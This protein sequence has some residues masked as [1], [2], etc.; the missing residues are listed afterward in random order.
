MS[1]PNFNF[2]KASPTTSTTNATTN[3]SFANRASRLGGDAEGT[4]TS[5]AKSFLQLS[6]SSESLPKIG[7][8]TVTPAEVNRSTSVTAHVTDSTESTDRHDLLGI[9]E[10]Y[11]V[12]AVD[13]DVD[14]LEEKMKQFQVG[15][16]STEKETVAQEEAPESV[17]KSSELVESE[18]IEKIVTDNH[19]ASANKDTIDEKSSSPSPESTALTNGIAQEVVPKIAQEPL[20]KPL[21]ESA[22]QSNTEQEPLHSESLL[23][24]SPATDVPKEAIATTVITMQPYDPCQPIL[25]EEE[26]EQTSSEANSSAALTST[27]IESETSRP[28]AK[29]QG[30]LTRASSQVDPK[31]QHQLSHKPFDFNTFLK[32]LKNKSAEPIVKYTKSFLASFTRQANNLTADQMIKA[33]EDFKAFIDEKFAEYEPFASMDDKDL[34]NSREGIEKLIM[35]C[36]YETCFSPSA[37]RKFGQNASSFMRVDVDEDSNFSLQ[38]EK[39]S[40]IL[41]VHLDVDLDQLIALKPANG[42][43]SID[44]MDHAREQLNKI[45][46]Y[47]APRD[48]IICVLNSCKVIFSLLKVSKNETNADSF[49][50]LLILVILKAKTPNFISNFR[51]ILRFRGS[52]WINHG[53]TSYYLSTI[54]AAVNFIQDIKMEDLTIDESHYNAHMEAWDAHVRQKNA[55]LAQPQPQHS[56]EPENRGI[57]SMSPSTVILASAGMIG[58]SLSNFLSLSPSSELPVEQAGPGTN[59]VLDAQIDE[60]FTQLAEIFPA[61]DKGILR[62]VIIMNDGDVERSL[63]ACLQLL[64]E[65]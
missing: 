15:R 11:D 21:A 53:E 5:L 14:L 20:S 45:N 22:L 39:Y 10:K 30:S 28:R 4:H 35:N 43:N 60:A 3:S 27:S 55:H 31:E 2:S 44:Y 1:L 61:L 42:K 58:K 51:Y 12:S 63:E 7:A 56:G 57:Q 23:N 54:E 13:T 8:G 37:V 50:P 24:E 46:E 25:K 6:R 33:V 41:G 65:E 36:L 26:K 17:E 59:T 19:Q 40:W 47:R 9:L 49:I 32:H 16:V 52:T 18:K 64:A 38:M 48:K 34:E 62:D 29:R